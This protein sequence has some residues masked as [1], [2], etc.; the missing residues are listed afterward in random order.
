MHYLTFPLFAAFPT[1]ML[2][3]AFSSNIAV[4]GLAMLFACAGVR[5]YGLVLERDGRVMSVRVLLAFCCMVIFCAAGMLT[6][7]LNR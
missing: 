2:L 1:W 7:Q 5:A 6:R 3:A 4:S